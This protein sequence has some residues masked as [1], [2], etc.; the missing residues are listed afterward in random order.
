MTIDAKRILAYSCLHLPYEHPK[1]FQF[2]ACLKKEY[3]PTVVVCLGDVTDLHQ[4]SKWP[5]HPECLSASDE[6]KQ[7]QEKTKQLAS[8]F[9]RQLVCDSNHDKR[10][11]RIAIHHGLPNA[12]VKTWQEVFKAPE[13]WKFGWEHEVG[14]ALAIHGDRY[15]GKD[16]IRN[17]TKDNFCSTIMGH[18]HTE[19]GVFW[20]ETKGGCVWGLQAGCLIDPMYA[21]F[22]YQQTNRNRPLIGAG[23]VVDGVPQ[24]VPMG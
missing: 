6:V 4:L 20:Q 19:A 13:G 17:A 3:K 7:A 22:E 9:P 24:F 16:G 11:S 23:I 5:K 1:A 15:S 10:I 2:L 21:A 18:I 8:L 12:V 14:P